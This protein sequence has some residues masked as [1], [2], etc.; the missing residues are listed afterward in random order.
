[1]FDLLPRFSHIALLLTVL[2]V[3]SVLAFAQPTSTSA[4]NSGDTAWMLAASALVMLMTPALGF[5]YAGMVGKKNLLS[6]L[7]HSLVIL[8]IA[9][10]LWVLIGYSLAFGPD[11]KGI[12][13]GLDWAGLRG[14]GLQPFNL[15]APGIPHLVFMIFQAKFAIITPALMIGA[16]VGR[17]RFPAFILFVIL[18]SLLIYYPVA[19]WVWGAGG[20]IKSMGVLD[21]AGGLVVHVTAGISALA[22]AL[23]IGPRVNFRNGNGNGNNGSKNGNSNGNSSGS[24]NGN[25]NN[26]SEEKPSSIPYIVLGTALLWFGWFGFNAGSALSA[27]GLAANAFVV[28]NT[29]AAAGALT[30]MCATWF[31]NKRPSLVGMCVGAVVGLVAITPASGFIDNLSAIAI[32]IIAGLLSFAVVSW[33]IGSH[34]DDTLDV[35]A[36]HG[37]GGI[38]GAILTGVFAS[39]AVNPAGANGLIYGN[40]HLVLNQIFAVFAVALYAFIITAVILKGLGLFMN[41]REDRESQEKGLDLAQLGETAYG[42]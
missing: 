4:I 12:I 3:F 10:L 21:F 36:A 2:A 7:M 15:Y 1:M 27:S 42:H 26:H 24:A 23:I 38:T 14:V 31:F 33:R 29:A 34:I 40:A 8:C 32:G 20:W 30:W 19:H 25:G 6:L 37:V 22:C 17:F 18:W 41:V 39:T 13:G 5:F 11:I 35:F 16:F 9:S 28:T